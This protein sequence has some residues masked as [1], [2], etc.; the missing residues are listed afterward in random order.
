MTYSM[1][2]ARVHTTQ[3]S[4]SRCSGD[5]SL[6]TYRAWNVRVARRVHRI[7]M[8]PAR[9]G[10]GGA[11]LTRPGQS[12]TVIAVP[13]LEQ[14]GRCQSDLTGD[15][16]A[17][18][19][20]PHQKK[21]SHICMQMGIRARSTRLSYLHAN[22]SSQKTHGTRFPGGATLGGS[23]SRVPC[24]SRLPPPGGAATAGFCALYVPALPR[25]RW[26]RAVC[27]CASCRRPAP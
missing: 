1:T 11:S 4:Q 13:T 12:A 17:C 10:R 23:R 24:L 3:R 9:A 16:F 26:T 22:G 20:S 2:C 18:N 25:A 8:T 7:C 27:G 15:A 21:S 6:C 5:S 14:V 19:F